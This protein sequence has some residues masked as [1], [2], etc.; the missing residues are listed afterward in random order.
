MGCVVNGMGEEWCVSEG[1]QSRDGCLKAGIAG[2][3]HQGRGKTEVGAVVRGVAKVVFQNVVEM[4]VYEKGGKAGVLF[5][6]G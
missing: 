4:G 1:A 6:S 3:L 2:A 5:F